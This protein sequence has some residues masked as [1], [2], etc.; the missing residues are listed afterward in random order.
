MFEVRHNSELGWT[1]IMSSL[2]PAKNIHFLGFALTNIN[3]YSWI[4]VRDRTV[5]ALTLPEVKSCLAHYGISPKI[6]TR[7]NQTNC[8][9]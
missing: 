9:N 3:R 6:Y 1:I 4:L 8:S 7:Q 5:D 2:T